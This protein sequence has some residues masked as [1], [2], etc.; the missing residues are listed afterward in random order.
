MNKHGKENT[1]QRRTIP[2]LRMGKG[3]RDKHRKNTNLSHLIGRSLPHYQFR[4]LDFYI[5]HKSRTISSEARRL[6]N[7]SISNKQKNRKRGRMRVR[8]WERTI[9]LNQRQRRDFKNWC[10]S[11]HK[12]HGIALFADLGTVNNEMTVR[13][14]IA[15]GREE[16]IKLI[17]SCFRV[18]DKE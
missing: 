9:G 1:I 14:K 3:K 15:D 11:D 6:I 16:D 18:G 8:I 7:K 4:C 5:P 17:S 12:S 13:D 2:G 10:K